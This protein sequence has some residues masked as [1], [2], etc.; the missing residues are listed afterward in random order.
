MARTGAGSYL[1]APAAGGQPQRWIACWGEGCDAVFP[2]SVH[3]VS[4]ACARCARRPADCPHDAP[5]RD[6]ATATGMYDHDC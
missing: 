6:A 3:T 1:P 4:G 5:S 2:A